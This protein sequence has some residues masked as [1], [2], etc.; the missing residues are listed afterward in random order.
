M[1]E[2][3][4]STEFSSARSD[5]KK[6]FL[7][8]LPSLKI[9]FSLQNTLCWMISDIIMPRFPVST[10]SITEA[11][12]RALVNIKKNPI[13]SDQVY[14]SIGCPIKIN[15]EWRIFRELMYEARPRTLVDSDTHLL[16]HICAGHFLIWPHRSLP[17]HL[18]CILTIFLWLQTIDCRQTW[19][20]TI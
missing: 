3:T 13:I 5:S 6:L 11:D 19:T 18:K 14:W 9:L 12:R 16:V 17:N 2:K 7:I 15:C 10:G 4:H 1:G 20:E 8:P